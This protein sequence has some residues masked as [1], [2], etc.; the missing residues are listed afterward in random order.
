MAEKAKAKSVLAWGIAFTPDG[1][2]CWLADR[3]LDSDPM[4]PLV[5]QTRKEARS[6]A[7]EYRDV[8]VQRVEIRPIPNAGKRKSA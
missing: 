5:F 4:R 1:R 3:H 6:Y 7:R 8:A 2:V